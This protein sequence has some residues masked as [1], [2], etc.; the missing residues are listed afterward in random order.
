MLKAKSVREACFLWNCDLLQIFLNVMLC[1]GKFI[2]RFVCLDLPIIF[3]P[4]Y[5]D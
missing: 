2:G 1:V 5:S 4:S 3:L